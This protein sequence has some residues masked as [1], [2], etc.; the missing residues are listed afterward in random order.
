M[1]IN[2]LYQCSALL[3]LVWSV[4]HLLG[5]QS[6][7]IGKILHFIVAVEM[8]AICFPAV[9]VATSHSLLAVLSAAIL[10]NEIIRKVLT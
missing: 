4:V 2:W 6:G 3:L 10:Y 7:I 9:E 8:G 5:K 1:S